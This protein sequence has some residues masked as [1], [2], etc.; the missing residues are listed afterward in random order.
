[1][2]RDKLIAYLRYGPPST[3]IEATRKG[4]TVRSR[5]AGKYI[6]LEELTQGGRVV[7]THKIT[8]EAVILIEEHS[9][10]ERSR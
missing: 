3:S 5:K 10:I 8:E 4:R 6:F 9:G 7:K 1:M 2:I